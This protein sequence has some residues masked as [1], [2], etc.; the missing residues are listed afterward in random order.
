MR[1]KLFFVL[2]RKKMELN[3]LQTQTHTHNDTQNT[4]RKI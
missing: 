4:R 1:K 2:S 3:I